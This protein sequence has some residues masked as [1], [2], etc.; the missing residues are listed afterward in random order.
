MCAVQ[1]HTM[2]GTASSAG[3][4]PR[5][6]EQLF[7]GARALEESQGWTFDMKVARQLITCLSPIP[8]PPLLP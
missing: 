7:A 1:T 3:I 5:A 8:P 2:L 4:I 6:V